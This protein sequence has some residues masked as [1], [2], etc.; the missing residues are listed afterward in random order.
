MNFSKRNNF[1]TR[2]VWK[3]LYAQKHLKKF[4]SSNCTKS[5]NFIKNCFCLPSGLELKKKKY[6]KN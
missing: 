5:K 4:N 3:L 6:S 2:A 1:E